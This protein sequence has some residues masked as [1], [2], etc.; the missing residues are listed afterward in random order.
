MVLSSG[1]GLCILNDMTAEVATRNA[2]PLGNK[3]IHADI[4]ADITIQGVEDVIDDGKQR[5]QDVALGPRTSQS[6]EDAA[7][8]KKAHEMRMHWDECIGRDMR[9]P[10]G[11]SH[12]AVLLIKWADELDDQNTAEEVSD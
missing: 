10:D 2:N 9:L 7:F 1:N 8:A 5:L 6:I 12:V 11:Y 4:H 3:L